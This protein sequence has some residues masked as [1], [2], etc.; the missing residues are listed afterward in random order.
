M[1]G[2]FFPATLRNGVNVYI[3]DTRKFKTNTVK[4]FL[5]NKLSRETVTRFALLPMVLKRGCNGLETN[6]DIWRYL[7]GLYGARFEAGVFKLGEHHV[8]QFGLEVANRKYVGTPED[9]LARGLDFL[10]RVVLEPVTTRGSGESF[11]IEYVEQEKEV[12]AREIA[13]IINEKS[14]YA[15]VRCIQEMC[16][17]EPFGLHE[18]GVAEDMPAIDGRSLYRLYSE[19]LEANPIDVCV[20][21]DVDRDYVLDLV[22]K[23]F[24]FTRRGGGEI[25]ETVRKA[26]PAEPKTITERQ[27]V[28]QGKLCLG[29][30]V[31]ASPR[32][33]LYP[34]MY[35]DGVFGGFVHSKLFTNVREKASLAYYASSTYNPAKGLLLVT[36]GIDV[37]KKD[38]AFERPI[39]TPSTKA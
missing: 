24:G 36:S 39:L 14:R 9:L 13:G 21:G 33:D 5:H 29:Y 35:Y 20:I 10:R 12:L 37:D 32:D 1:V 31:N 25:P 19:S 18:L 34:L 2:D 7:D 3:H 17:G 6:K 27:D 23:A 30:R 26:A 8:I 11:R 15:V 38:Q 4:V 16:A 28:S 22:D